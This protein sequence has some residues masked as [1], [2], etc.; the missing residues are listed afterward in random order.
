MFQ[1]I[2]YTTWSDILCIVYCVHKQ[3]LL[4]QYNWNAFTVEYNIHKNEKYILKV[5]KHNKWHA[6]QR[7]AL[8][9]YIKWY[10]ASRPAETRSFAE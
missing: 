6:Q 10:I 7:Y 2:Q 8:H 4:R 9:Q 3:T 1:G 5:E